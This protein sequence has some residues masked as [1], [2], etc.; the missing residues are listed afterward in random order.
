MITH[1]GIEPGRGLVGRFGDTVILIR[2]DAAAGDDAD[3]VA[4]ELLDLA[5]EVAADPGREPRSPGTGRARR[6]GPAPETAEPSAAGQP[7][8]PGIQRPSA[9][10]RPTRMKNAPAARNARS[11]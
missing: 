1:V 8:P 3:Q 2:R 5:A 9:M 7:E 11:A 10:P 4:Q 6:D